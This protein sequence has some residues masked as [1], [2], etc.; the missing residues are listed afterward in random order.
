[1]N[2]TFAGRFTFFCES[3]SEHIEQLFNY[4]YHNY[5]D[6]QWLIYVLYPVVIT[7]ILPALIFLF[8]YA[9]QLFLQ[10]YRLRQHFSSMLHMDCWDG[11]RQIIAAVWAAHG[12]IWHGE[13]LHT[14][15]IFTR[16]KLFRTQNLLNTLVAEWLNSWICEKKYILENS[17][18]T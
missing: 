8:L 9:S 15:C 10:L 11:A 18:K 14:H 5:V 16:W 3:V 17:I 12:K 6:I 7:F 13:L 1:M 4:L 2:A